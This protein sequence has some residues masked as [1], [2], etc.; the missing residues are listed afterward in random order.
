MDSARIIRKAKDLNDEKG[1]LS[2]KLPMILK[3]DFVKVSK[4]HNIP[5]NT[6]I[7]SM[8]DE[9]INGESKKE[10]NLEVVKRFQVLVDRKSE[11]E[12][13]IYDIGDDVVEALDGRTYDFGSELENI[14]FMIKQM[15]EVL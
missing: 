15:K 9:F 11:L 8:I 5:V 13:I 14:E 3:E 6:L 4:K 10:D 2:I 12:K 7:V 1:S